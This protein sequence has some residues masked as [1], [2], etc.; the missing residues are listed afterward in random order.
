MFSIARSKFALP[1]Q[2]VFLLFN[3]FGLL[4]GIIYN[5][6]TPDLYENNAH[7]KIGWIVTWVACAQGVMSLIFVYAG[8]GKPESTSY[9]RAAF[10]PVSTDEM[11]DR[12][13]DLNY[14]PQSYRW[15]RDSGQGTE[16]NSA[17]LN[18]RLQSPTC[19]SPVEDYDGFEKPEDQELRPGRAPAWWQNTVIERFFVSRVP[20]MLSTR[21]LRA[22]NIVYSV[23]DR[24]IL[25][26]SFIAIAT[27]G[28]TYGGIMV[29]AW[30][31]YH[32]IC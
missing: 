22:L 24:I 13:A 15:S 30:L 32:E 4:L 23:I 26:L 29:S 16:R 21:V 2:L 7:H 3:A 5:S 20:D 14:S 11:D 1:S 27:G 6:Q 25:P 12:H 9:E 17:S 10:L 18:S 19:Q 31:G 28:V 8:R